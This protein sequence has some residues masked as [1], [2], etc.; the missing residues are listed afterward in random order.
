M[1]PTAVAAF[2]AALPLARFCSKGTPTRAALRVRPVRGYLPARGPAS[3]PEGD[4]RSEDRARVTARTH[5]PPPSSGTPAPQRPIRRRRTAGVLAEKKHEREHE[6]EVERTGNAQPRVREYN[7]CSVCAR[8]ADLLLRDV[9]YADLPLTLRMKLH[10]DKYRGSSWA[11]IVTADLLADLSVAN[12][13]RM[14]ESPVDFA[15]VVA[16]FLAAYALADLA[17]GIGTWFTFN[18][19][20]N[21]ERACYCDGTRDFARRIATN[22]GVV[23]PFLTLLL[24]HAPGDPLVYSF[25]VYFLSFVSVIPALVDWSGSSSFPPSVARVL[26]RIGLALGDHQ[27]HNQ[28]S[29]DE[30]EAKAEPMDLDSVAGGLFASSRNPLSVLRPQTRRHHHSF[31]NRAWHTILAEGRFF[32]TLEKWIFVTSRGKL[33]PQAWRHDPSARLKAFASDRKAHIQ[34][35]SSQV[36]KIPLHILRENPKGPP[37]PP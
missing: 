29:L 3:A 2:A 5:A 28:G 26:R 6:L 25:L 7:V 14:V 37:P 11:I 4:A 12:I 22:C 10:F 19:L 34:A 33:V 35:M 21:G 1:T 36:E 9:P 18:F 24:I 8:H 15:A 23:L 27:L 30:D 32:A 13:L 20:T 31:L 17:S 16:G